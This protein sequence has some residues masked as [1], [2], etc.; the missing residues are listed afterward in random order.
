MANKQSCGSF[1]KDFRI[2]PTLEP[3]V[4]IPE[5]MIM[6]GDRAILYLKTQRCKLAQ[7]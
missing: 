5:P 3:P 6:D 1:K 7:H 2:A 4:G